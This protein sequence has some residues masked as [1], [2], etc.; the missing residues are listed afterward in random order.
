MQ[1]YQIQRLEESQPLMEMLRGIK[2]HI[3]KTHKFEEG[4]RQRLI[5]V[6]ER[7]A[8]EI[9]GIARKTVQSAAQ[10]VARVGIDPEEIFYGPEK[11]L[12]TSSPSNPAASSTSGP[13]KQVTLSDGSKLWVGQ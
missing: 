13:G 9:E 6:T 1:A 3:L 5:E 2:G 7:K 10:Q 4:T 12:L 11:E 8:Q